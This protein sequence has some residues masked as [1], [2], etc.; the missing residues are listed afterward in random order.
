MIPKN[1]PKAS[2][3]IIEI[4]DVPNFCLNSR[5]TGS[6]SR[7]QYTS[8]CSLGQLQ[9]STT[10]KLA[11]NPFK[12]ITVQS[13]IKR[14]HTILVF[15]DG[16]DMIEAFSQEALKHFATGQMK[17]WKSLQNLTNAQVLSDPACSL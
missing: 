12:K 10:I 7:S 6:T 8:I 4:C 13:L 14:H 9:S 15:D 11:Y 16:N 3:L 2:K 1:L 5:R 17:A